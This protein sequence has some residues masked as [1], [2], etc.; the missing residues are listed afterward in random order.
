MLAHLSEMEI[1]AKQ[2]PRVALVIRL[3]QMKMPSFN[4]F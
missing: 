2:D 4:H 3:S 1:T